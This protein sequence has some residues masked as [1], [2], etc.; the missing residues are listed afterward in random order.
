M[1]KKTAGEVFN[2][3][4]DLANFVGAQQKQIEDLTTRVQY[5]VDK[6]PVPL[7]DNGITFPDGEFWGQA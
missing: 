4:Q 6:W 1:S 2:D 3:I 7:E 5:L